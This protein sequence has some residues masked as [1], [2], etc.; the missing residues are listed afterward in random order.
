MP[1]AA[2]ADPALFLADVTKRYGRRTALDGVTLTVDRGTVV[3]LIGP[4]GAGKTTTMR[5][6]LDIVRASSGTVR[7]LGTEP[8]AGGP[9]L[10]RR[11]GYLPGELH[12]DARLTARGLLEHYG[13]LSAAPDSSDRIAA[14]SDRLGL[15]RARPVRA[16][17]K[18]NKQKVGLVQA[19]L[20]RPELLVLDE[21]TSGLDPLVQ[22]EFL[23]LVREATAAGATVLLSSHVISEVQ[24]AADR[25]AVLRDGRIIATDSVAA[26]R[27]R[28]ARDIR[29]VVDA[30]DGPSLTERLSAHP[31]IAALA[32]TPRADGR[33]MISARLTGG[34][35]ELMTELACYRLDD[36]MI[37]EPD[38]ERAVLA[39]YGDG[40]ERAGAER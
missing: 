28:A 20:H 35:T 14:L 31:T 24:H 10:R 18:G 38:L 4:N 13:R 9:T 1:S 37:A 27:R 32:A 36:L 15:D 40:D 30:A 34:L 22:R 25:V 5:I 33:T 8:R 21:P 29:V 3:G 12:M 19:F 17:S 16:L 26:M 2:A 6:L 39:Y 23:A 11:I 7:V